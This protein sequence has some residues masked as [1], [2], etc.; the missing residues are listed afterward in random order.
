MS[1]GSNHITSR[2]HLEI[3]LANES[4]DERV[5]SQTQFGEAVQK[6]EAVGE[7]GQLV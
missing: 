7:C 4:N 5:V 1:F 2:D 6:D 3:H